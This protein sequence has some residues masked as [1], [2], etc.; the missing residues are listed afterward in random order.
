MR[1]EEILDKRIILFSLFYG[2]LNINLNISINCVY[3]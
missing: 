2:Y 1:E 3:A